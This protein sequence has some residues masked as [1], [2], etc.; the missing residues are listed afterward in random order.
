MAIFEGGIKLVRAEVG[1]VRGLPNDWLQIDTIW[2]A[3][4]PLA[5]NYT[6]FIQL[7]NAQGQLVTQMDRPP[8]LGLFPTSQWPA[9]TAHGI[10]DRFFVPLPVED[11]VREDLPAGDYRLI[12]GLYHSETLERLNVLETPY[13]SLGDAVVVAEGPV[14]VDQVHW[15]IEKTP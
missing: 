12:I 6:I 5:N 8:L 13:E 7:L 2:S 9:P 15:P 3:D 1:L 11:P 4:Q 14:R 10:G